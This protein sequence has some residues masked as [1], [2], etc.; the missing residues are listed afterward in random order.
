[1][2]F[3][4]LFFLYSVER[5]LIKRCCSIVAGVAVIHVP[6]IELNRNFKSVYVLAVVSRAPVDD[7][8]VCVW[9]V[10]LQ[11]SAS[12][13][14][15]GHTYVLTRVSDDLCQCDNQSGSPV[16]SVTG[17]KTSPLSLQVDIVELSSSALS[18]LPTPP[19]EG[20]TIQLPD[21]RVQTTSGHVPQPPRQLSPRQLDPTSK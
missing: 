1:M 3:F 12:T 4:A 5:V 11:D 10:M 8:R 20:A 17:G 14:T 15:E 6:C 16:S 7:Q 21:P 9:V 2:P 18:L 13:S 19:T